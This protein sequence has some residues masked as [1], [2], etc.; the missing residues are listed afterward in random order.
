MIY[1]IKNEMKRIRDKAMSHFKLYL[2]IYC[3]KDKLKLLFF[4]CEL[5][6]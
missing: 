4:V 1:K 5:L 2:E 3:L 6:E